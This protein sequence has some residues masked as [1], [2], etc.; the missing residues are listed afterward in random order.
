MAIARYNANGTPDTS[1][2]TNG[3]VTL[4]FKGS[5]DSR[6]DALALA[7]TKILL[8]GQT[9]PGSF[10]TSIA[11]T[12]LNADGSPDATFG[13]KGRVKFNFH[14]GIDEGL[15]VLALS[16]GKVL[17]CGQTNDSSTIE[18]D[19]VLMRLTSAGKK[20]TTFGGGDGT[21]LDDLG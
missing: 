1:F 14:S 15:G 11:V 17:L 4:Q 21:V 18:G 8:A 3:R 12:R 7:G 13:T 9:S 5:S 16:S 19:V 2:H 10:D 6:C 20:D